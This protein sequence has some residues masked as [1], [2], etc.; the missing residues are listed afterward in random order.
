ME[1]FPVYTLDSAPEAA[2]HQGFPVVDEEGKL[3]GVLTRRDLLDQKHD[4]KTKR[5]RHT[6]IRSDNAA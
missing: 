3:I 1:R 6:I 2:V 4:A 5:R